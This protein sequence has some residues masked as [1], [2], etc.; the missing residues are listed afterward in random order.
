MLHS[1]GGGSLVNNDYLVLIYICSTVYDYIPTASISTGQA[2]VIQALTLLFDQRLGES[3][4]NEHLDLVRA[5]SI[6]S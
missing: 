1:F 2:E 3:H 6:L 5:V 4:I